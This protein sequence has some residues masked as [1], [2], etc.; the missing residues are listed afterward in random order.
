MLF[1]FQIKFWVMIDKLYF[2]A[3]NHTYNK[4]PHNFI[5]NWSSSILFMKKHI[6]L[7]VMILPT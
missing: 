5:L 3:E 6:L 2:K 7:K 4:N 1:T